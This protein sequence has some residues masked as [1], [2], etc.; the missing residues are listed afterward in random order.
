MNIP[1]ITDITTALRIY[2][3]HSELGNKEMAILFGQRSSATISNLKRVAKKE[4]IKRNI[5]S[6]GA[7]KVN[8][9]IAFEVW[10]IDVEDLERRKKKIEELNL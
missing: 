8:T 9:A 6:Y 7:N 2:Y 4:M 5:L 3:A 1:P 10:G